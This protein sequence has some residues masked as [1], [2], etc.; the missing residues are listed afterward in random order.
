MLGWLA[1]VLW[2]LWLGQPLTHPIAHTD[3]DSY[4][5]V[6]RAL[7]GGPGGFSSETPLFRRAGYPLLIAPAYLLGSDFAATYKIIQIVNAAVSALSLPLA[8]LLARRMFGLG[9]WAGL[10]AAFAAATVPAG[11][12]WSLVGMTDAIMAPLLLGWFLAMHWWL[13]DAGRKRAAVTVGLLTG[14]LYAVHI[15]GTILLAVYLGFLALALWRRRVPVRLAG[16]SLVPVALSAA[17]NQ[18]IILWLG[19]KVH[20]RGDIVGAG[21][22]EVFTDADRLRVFAGSFGTNVWY[23]CVVTA[24]LAGLAWT[25][26]AVEMLRPARDAAFRWTAGLALA[27]TFAVTAGAALILAGLPGDGDALYSRYVQAFVPFWLLFGVA[28]LINEAALL[29]KPVLRYTV[30]PVLLLVAGGLFV[31]Y[32]LRYA[33]EH[34]QRLGYGTFG[35]P[36]LI[37]VTAGWAR[38]RPY[39]GTVIALAG[40]AVL[41]LLTRLRAL[42]IPA[43]ALIVAANAVTMSVM[44]DRLVEPLGERFST[45]ID[46]AALGVG[47]GDRVALG[48]GMTREGYFVMYHEVYWQDLAHVPAGEPPADVD[49]VIGRYAPGVT[50]DGAAYGFVLLQASPKKG[51]IAVWRRQ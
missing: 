38:L 8:Y 48:G 25:V 12:F 45:P 41:V 20:L 36:D 46:L 44:R 22:L 16:L 3:E 50:W 17:L 39:A 4:L 29:R 1:G 14:I 49:V 23:M 35:G 19:D 32:R 2:R 31:A 5:N 30:V 47:P 6:A 10:A 42:V 40:L 9:R 37:T 11:V 33:A 15:R 7:A 28:A 26:S 51:Q 13:R 27:G 18:A 21:T 34:G 24:G 43:L